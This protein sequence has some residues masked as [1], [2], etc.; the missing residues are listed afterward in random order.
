MPSLQLQCAWEIRLSEHFHGR[1]WRFQFRNGFK[2]LQEANSAVVPKHA[3]ADTTQEWISVPHDIVAYIVVVLCSY[4]SMYSLLPPATH[5]GHQMQ[6]LSSYLHQC[7]EKLTIFLNHLTPVKGIHNYQHLH[8]IK[9]SPDHVFAKRTCTNDA[10][11]NI[12]LAHNPEEEFDRQILPD[13]LPDILPA[14]GLSETRLAYCQT[15][16]AEYTNVVQGKPYRFVHV[17]E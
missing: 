10:D 12:T 5:H 14:A 9:N 17:G 16:L 8:I 7:G 2:K 11:D 15:D 13:N 3:S 4:A 6:H 1:L